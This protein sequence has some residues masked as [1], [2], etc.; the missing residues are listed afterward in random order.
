MRWWLPILAYL[1]LPLTASAQ[2]ELT[3]FVGYRVGGLS[4]DPGIVCIALVGVECP[5][6]AQSRDSELYGL[7]AD[8]PIGSNWMLELL[9]SRQETEIE[10][11]PGPLEIVILD[12]DFDLSIL[13]V[14]LL[15]QWQRDRI[16]PFM[17]VGIGVARLESPAE[18]VE[19]SAIDEG[20][21]AAS[22]AAGLKLPL[23][24]WLAL[25]LEGRGYWVDLPAS[26]DGE[27]IQTELT[28]GLTFRW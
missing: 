16:A 9:V 12:Q 8:V 17:A 10:F 13:Q 4:F 28:T 15:R 5:A 27:M 18:T 11:D 3:P 19:G 26:L 23:Q 14:G 21:L 7:V 22:V 1:L 24:D 6:E 20:R 25:R 2:F